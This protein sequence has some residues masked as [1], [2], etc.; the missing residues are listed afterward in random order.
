MVAVPSAEMSQLAPLPEK[1]Q[2][3]LKP[4]AVFSRSGESRLYI[5]ESELK[6]TSILLPLEAQAAG[7]S[8]PVP[9]SRVMRGASVVSPS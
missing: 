2:T 4:S 9:D 8:P 3:A 5:G 1:V 6:R 7:P